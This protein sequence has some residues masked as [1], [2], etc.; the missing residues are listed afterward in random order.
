MNT[1]IPGRDASF[2]VKILRDGA[3]FPVS[4]T[5]V[6][7]V[8][9]ADGRTLLTTSP[10]ALTDTTPSSFAIGVVP[11]VIP[12]VVTSTL[13]VGNVVLVV[14]GDFGVH[15]FSASVE[16]E[17]VGTITSLF[18]R[19]IVVDEIRADRL[20]AASAGI[21]QDVKISDD[22]I[23]HKVIA[24]EAEIRHT[25][26]VPLVPTK[27]YPSTPTDAQVAS[28]NGMA[29]EID[30][31]YDYDPALFARDKW[32]YLVTKNRPLIDIEY[33]RFAYPT[34]DVGFFELP[35][36]WI[37]YDAQ[38]GHVR[39]VPSSTAPLMSLAAFG[40]TT[41]VSGQTVPSMIQLAYTAGL[42]DAANTYP[43]LVDVIKKL[44]V[45][46]I[47]ADAFL[48]QSGS[49][50][51]DGLSQSLSVDMSKYSDAIDEILNGPKGSNGGLMTRIHG[52]RMV[53]I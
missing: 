32:G 36:D 5:L 19:D 28:L 26:R 33:M 47:V 37:R 8:Y 18:I 15:R 13:P 48:P 22:Y 7:V 25:L 23:W 53:G 30:V 51:A 43:E 3:P 44:A 42:I 11:V 21:L 10:I 17:A 24:A 9:S 35:H 29:W 31:G 46:K 12:S 1:I 40:F 2:S 14:R 39:I 52:I 4:G 16:I 50:S 49:I 41:F 45:L 20:M 6:C 34:Q 38:Y 27:F